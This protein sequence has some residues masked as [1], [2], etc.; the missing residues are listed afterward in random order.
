MLQLLPV[1]RSELAVGAAGVGLV[2]VA[3][4][5][6]FCENTLSIREDGVGQLEDLSVDCFGLEYFRGDLIVVDR[7]CIL[8]SHFLS[9]PK[10]GETSFKRMRVRAVGNL[11]LS[12]TQKRVAVPTLLQL[13]FV[14][15]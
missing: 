3:A 10:I 8:L 9:Y 7:R 15:P 13:N 12:A 11:T 1:L 4:L 2:V 14:E 6:Q 5:Q